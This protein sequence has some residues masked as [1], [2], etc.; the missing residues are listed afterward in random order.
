MR[1][2]N[3]E[4]LRGLQVDYRFEPSRR[5]HRK[6]RRFLASEDAVD[7]VRGSAP[8]IDLIGAIRNESTFGRKISVRINRRKSMTDR[9]DPCAADRAASCLALLPAGF[10]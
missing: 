6:V 3:V 7:V 4:R 8:L 1:H 2:F 5:L 10:A 9:T